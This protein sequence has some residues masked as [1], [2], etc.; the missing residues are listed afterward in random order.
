M[1]TYR[2]NLAF[3]PSYY[4]LGVALV[5]NMFCSQFLQLYF[6]NF[7]AQGDSSGVDPA[8]WVQTGWNCP[9]TQFVLTCP[10]WNPS[11]APGWAAQCILRFNAVPRPSSSLETGR[12]TAV[13][14][15]HASGRW[16]ERAPSLIAQ[17]A[18]VLGLRYCFYFLFLP[19]NSRQSR[20]A[21]SNSQELR[22]SC[23]VG[24]MLSWLI[25]FLNFKK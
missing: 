1:Y 9:P 3:G 24:R 11:V 25:L 15:G 16:L 5:K 10:A 12:H 22:T 2:L 23:I 7:S 4:H 8:F 21:A 20:K 6:S 14:S 13:A 18:E 17:K 19:S